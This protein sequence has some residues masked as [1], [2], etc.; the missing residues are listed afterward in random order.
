MNWD[1]SEEASPVEAVGAYLNDEGFDEFG[2]WSLLTADCCKLSLSCFPH[3]SKEVVL[4][5]EVS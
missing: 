5:V 2:I 3:P 1:K 4:C